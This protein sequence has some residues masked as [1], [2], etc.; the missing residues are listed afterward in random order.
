MSTIVAPPSVKIRRRRK[1]YIITAAIIL[2]LGIS[3]VFY[4]NSAS[5]QQ[6]VR[7]RVVLELEH[8]TG[9]KVEIESLTWKLSTLQIQVRGLTIHGLE[10]AN[11]APYAHVDRIDISVK[12]LSFFS[13]KVALSKV[14]I[15]HVTAHLIIYPNGTTNQPAPIEKAGS[16][17]SEKTRQQLVDL[18]VNQVE[19][20]N[21][22]LILNEEQIPFSIAGER[23]DAGVTY[24]AQDHGYESNISM[25]LSSARWRDIA[26][27]RGDIALQLLLRS[28]EA[29]IKSLRVS[30]ARSTLQAGGTL[31]NF[32]HP[33]L[34]LQYQASLDLLSIAKL[35]KISEI[36]GGHGDIKGFF[37][38]QD[39]R[40]SS[41]GNVS[42]R[43]GDWQDDLLHIPDIS[44]ISPFSITAEKISFSK[45][46]GHAF[47]GNVQ[48]DFQ[49]F[50]WV[51]QAQNVINR[52]KSKSPLKETANLQ[53][54]GLEVGKVAVAFYKQTLPLEKV[55]L[56]GRTSGTITTSWTG[57]PKNVVAN[58][59][60]E[61]DA[62]QN[63]TPEQVPVTAHLQA[64][65]HGDART[66]DVPVLNAATR[67]IR[68]NATGQLGSDKAQ[69]KIS[70]NSTDLHELR[71]ALAALSPGTRIPVLL[72][73]RASYNGSVSGKLDALSTHGRLELENFDT[74]LTHLQISAQPP[75][76]SR[77]EPGRAKKEER[78]HW[79]AL[80]GD[81]S[82]SP[83]MV[84]LQ[85]STVRRGKA[86]VDFSTS[87]TLQKGVFDDH[88]SQ[89]NVNLHIQDADVADVQTLLAIRYPIQGVLGADIKASG[90]AVNLHG[91]GNV[92][93]ARLTAWGEPFRQLKTQVDFTG[94][95]LQLSNIFLAHN[96]AQL[97]GL[98]GYNF[99]DNHF[100]FDLTAANIDLATMQ[101]VQLPRLAV[102]GSAGFH[103]TGSGTSDNPQ[104]AGQ[105]QFR[106][107][108]LNHELVGDSD[109]N[110]ET[111][112][113]DLVLRGRSNFDNANLDMDGTVQMRGDW[114]G[115]VKLK[116]THLDF[117]PL[118][119]AYLEGRVTGHSSVAGTIDIS[120]PFLRPRDLIITGVANQLSAELENVKLQNDGP[121]HFSMDSEFARLNQF[122]LVGENTDVYVVGGIG[123]SG[124]HILELRSNGRVNLKLLQGYNPD[125]IAYGPASFTVNVGG[126]MAHP[127]L[128]GRIDLADAGI[129]IVDLPNGLSHINGSLVFAQDRMQIEKLSAQTGG[130]EVNVGGFL[131]YRSG[132]YFD[133]TAS[134]KDIRLRYPP[135]VSS[136]ADASLRFSGSE[137]SSL[138]S[139]DVTV[140]RFGMNPRF[141]F[142][143]YLAQSRKSQTVP[144]LNP[145]LDNMRLDVHINSTPE[146]Q[147][148]TSLARLSGDLDLHARGTASRP[149]VLGRVN[150]AEGDVFFNGTKYRLE[151]GDVSF[152][153]PLT[154]EPVVNIEMSARV[155]DYDVTIGLHGSA[156]GGKGMSMTYRSDPPLSNADIISLLAFGRTRGQD[157][158]SAGQPAGSKDNTASN[159]ILGQAL[160][161]AVG[162]RVQRLLGASRVKIDP[163]YVGTSNNTSA[164]VTLEQQINNNITLTYITSLAQS[165]E[166][167]VQVEYNI[168]KNVSIV[169]VRDQ[170]G[171]LGFDVHIRR[172]K[173]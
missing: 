106:K 82:Y 105:V 72:E 117:D 173:K 121:V 2:L 15:D 95:D 49:L 124:D 61:V 59:N 170:N 102:E 1:V 148:E 65:Y 158:Y 122:H 41:Q 25:S 51:T 112:G 161:A 47:G 172:R 60:L 45:I 74:E 127:Q 71:P 34:Q 128:S 151:R 54:S 108:V 144:T 43:D 48:G 137:R 113:A 46:D 85:H 8:M 5:F 107:L 16:A 135:G 32:S 133:L 64:T 134:G 116:F 164:R 104:I 98:F 141:D 11:E 7:K 12:I 131:A 42:A 13:P 28:N 81:L 120:G 55:P 87:A 3:A 68:L 167:V 129:S 157:V 140:T 111:R 35:A 94:H 24:S 168:D 118:I 162:D 130:G 159:A 63:A 79:D 89:V 169:A 57:S 139:G 62:P 96:G 119:H 20:T 132:L 50:N 22:T 39:N 19:V 136:S 97:N 70:V 17:A 166:T 115:Q 75:Q 31:R 92:Q 66:F 38:Y 91:S 142:A 78:I 149:A 27:Q 103:I 152:S 143:Q 138:L 37:R 9:G 44:A 21:G 90:T 156:V 110:A 18:S 69:A 88:L 77:V 36:R 84:S 93:M 100:R 154:I 147:V 76:L 125:I 56:V 163:L 145:F 99:D 160:N 52:T 101:R 26:P 6:T 123:V 155:Q 171:V 109:I 30:T 33:D 10:A 73:G 146:L 14:T 4:L 86:A 126:N 53:M 40:F 150:I 23:L 83:S 153:N 165:T 114:P 29:L 80:V 58:F 67:A